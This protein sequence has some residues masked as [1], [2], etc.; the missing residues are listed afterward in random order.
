MKWF[1]LARKSPDPA[2][3]GEADRAYRNLAPALSR[4]RTTAWAFPVFST[5]WH[6]VFAYSQVKTDLRIGHLPLR[7]YISMRFIGDTRGS[8][9]SGVAGTGPQYLSES[10]AILAFGLATRSWHGAMSWFEAGESLKYRGPSS[11]GLTPD[12]RGGVSFSR[13]FGHLLR[14]SSHGLFAETNGDGVYVSRFAHDMLLYSQNRAGY[15]LRASESAGFQAQLYW[16]WNITLDAKSQYW[17]NYIE[18]GPGI[19]FRFAALPASLLFSV[20]AMRG[21]YLIQEGNPR[22]PNFS[23]LRA[24]IWYAFTH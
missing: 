18:T 7:P 10:S 9:E 11:G 21:H 15:T 16:N 17:A 20:N 24:G 1:N 14:S 2:V 22:G 4:F 19:R 3:A 6:D 5:R 13:G 12:Y 8:L 23:D